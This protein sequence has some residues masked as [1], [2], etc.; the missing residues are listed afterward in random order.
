MRLAVVAYPNLR[1]TD[2]N[3]IESIR[4]K[5]DP[6]ATRLGVHFTLVFPFDGEPAE[7]IE[8]IAAATRTT[9][10]I[11]FESNSVQ[12]VSNVSSSEAH[13]FLVPSQ[14]A[15]EILGLYERLHG[16]ILRSRRLL[17]IPYV[18]HLTIAAHS[19]LDSAE[20]LAQ[21]LRLAI[22]ERPAV[23]GVV[24]SIELVD[25]SAQKVETVAKFH[26]KNEI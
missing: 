22:A 20:A 5:H 15:A 26:L 16:N 14:G 9:S 19:S 2:R 3:W 24:S 1:S 4:I 11:P 23:R 13:V 25:L 6:Q 8:E 10:Q 18:P 12:V 7:L 21:T 17:G